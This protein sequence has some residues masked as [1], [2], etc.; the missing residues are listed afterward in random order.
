MPKRWLLTEEFATRQRSINFYSLGM[1]LPNPDP[2]LKKLGKDITT[3]KELLVEP[4]VGACVLSRKAGVQSL[5]WSIDRG[6]ARSNQSKI[7]QKWIEKLDT[8]K[9]ISE[10]LDSTLFGYQPLEVTW[11]KDGDLL[12]PGNLT[13]KPPEW[14]IFSYENKLRFRSKENYIEGEELPEYK[15]LCP[16]YQSSYDNPYGIPSLSKVFWPVT[17]KKGGLQFWSVFTEKYGMPAI[18]GKIRR[19]APEE[20]KNELAVDLDNMVQDAIFVIPDDSSIELLEAGGKSASSQVYKELINLCNEEISK[21]ILGQT[22]TTQIGDRGSYAASQTHMGVRQDIL[23]SDKKI[24][25]ETF[26]NLI[27]WIYKINFPSSGELPVFSMWQ[28]EDVDLTLAQ[29]DKILAEAGVKYTKAYFIK[30]YGLEEEDFEIMDKQNTSTDTPVQFAESSNPAT[31]E[32]GLQDAVSDKELQEIGEK[33]L[34]PVIKLVQES[35]SYEEIM[36]NLSGQ[37]PLMNTEDLEALLERAMFW[38]ETMGRQSDITK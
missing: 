15:F 28:E 10:I 5:E 20:E 2:V 23:D 6:K 7:I 29:R 25:E 36:E 11:I 31:D 27:E 26:N 16:S 1:F 8:Q 3:Y 33:I 13:G 18:V 38:S 17:F 9:V 24:V 32:T 34:K 21:A 30:N 37:Y 4:H 12:L 22:L 19:G 14:F 35:N